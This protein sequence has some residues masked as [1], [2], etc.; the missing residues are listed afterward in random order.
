M[1][2]S[3]SL[4][5]ALFLSCDGGSDPSTPRALVVGIDGVRPDALDT[6]STP[7]MDALASDGTIYRDAFA[8]GQPGTRTEQRTLSG[9]GW[10]SIL[11]GVWVDKHGVQ[12]NDFAG[13]RFDEYP[14]FFRRIR[15]VRP[16]ATLSSFVTWTPIHDQILGTEDADVAFSPSAESSEE[17]DALVA[18]AVVDHLGGQDPDVVFVHLDNP[19]AQGHRHTFSAETPEY[20]AAIE[21]ADAQVSSMVE[22]I[23][24]RPEFEGEDWLVVVITDHGG[25]GNLH[26]GQ[27]TEERTIPLIVSQ[28]APKKGTAFASGP[29]QVVVPSLVLWHLGVSIDSD[30][31]WEGAD[32]VR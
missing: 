22:A 15:E 8:G 27:S 21:G 12:F 30:W 14:H 1:T 17:A 10:S 6:A 2:R 18:A 5:L 16:D 31:G 24:A 26:G 25:L 13:S 28:V 3:W 32:S 9:P 19:D 11:T 29:G 23:R 20:L 7:G 4:L